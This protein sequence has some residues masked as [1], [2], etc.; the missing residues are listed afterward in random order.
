MVGWESAYRPRLSE[1][2][3]TIIVSR[4]QLPLC[5][6][7]IFNCPGWMIDFRGPYELVDGKQR[8]EAVRKFMRD[9]LPVFGYI[10]GQYEDKLPWNDYD[11][12]WTVVVSL[13]FS[14]TYH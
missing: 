13:L 5:K 4:G 2:Y 8:L 9:E 14:S 12:I 1:R 11:F 3:V 6:T 7:L 10:K